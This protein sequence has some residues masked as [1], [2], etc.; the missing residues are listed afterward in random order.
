MSPSDDAK[1]RHWSLLHTDDQLAYQTLKTIVE[2][3]T[4]RTSRDRAAEN[5]QLLMRHLKDYIIRHDDNDWKRSLVCGIAW[6]GD[7]IAVST[8]QLRKLTGKC[9]SSVN[10]GFESIGFIP[11]PM[12]ADSAEKLTCAIPLMRDDPREARKWTVRI[13]C[14]PPPLAFTLPI[15]LSP[16]LPPSGLPELTMP[17]DLWSED[18]DAGL[19]L[20][21]MM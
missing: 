4:V 5:F 20:G 8:A 13:P 6:L 16:G 19:I 2:Q 17:D 3:L 9:K 10:N 14:G 12:S 7:A 21:D 11:A 18:E 1:P 15:P